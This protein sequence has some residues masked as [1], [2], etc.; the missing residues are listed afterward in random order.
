MLVRSHVA[1]FNKTK[2]KYNSAKCFAHKKDL[3]LLEC[4]VVG[5]EWME[6]DHAMADINRALVLFKF[7]E[8]NHSHT[9]LEL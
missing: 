5:Q 4:C 3:N 8:Q 9:S 6:N 7:L 1:D 2:K